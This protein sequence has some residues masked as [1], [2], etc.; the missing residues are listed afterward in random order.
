MLERDERLVIFLRNCLNDQPNLV[1]CNVGWL[2]KVFICPTY[3]LK[4]NY[5]PIKISL[6][7]DT[8]N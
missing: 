2:I 6:F 4:N 1:F 7:G 5:A 3:N 8:L